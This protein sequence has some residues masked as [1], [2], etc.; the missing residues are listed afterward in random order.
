ME[1][2]NQNQR[3]TRMEQAMNDSLEAICQLE[4]A[5]EKYQRILGDLA[6]LRSYYES[7]QWRKDFED[8]EAGKLSNGLKR[9]VLSE[10]GVY[11]LLCENDELIQELAVL[12]GLKENGTD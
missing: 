9:G 4:C 5:V 11:N 1:T 7:E 3:I 12:A 10:D 6:D 8:D 2:E